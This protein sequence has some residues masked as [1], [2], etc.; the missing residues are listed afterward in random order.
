[1]LF[2]RPIRY[3][4]GNVFFEDFLEP[5]S[6]NIFNSAGYNLNRYWIN[7]PREADWKYM[8]SKGIIF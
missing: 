5:V 4:Y 1:M 6:E 2:D 7:I 3:P 8:S